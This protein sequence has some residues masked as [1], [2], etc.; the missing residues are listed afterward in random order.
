MKLGLLNTYHYDL[1]P[2]NYQESYQPMAMDFLQKYFP[3]VSIETYMVAQGELPQGPSDCDAWLITGSPMSAYDSDKWVIDLK[4][5]IVECDQEKVKM[6]GICFGHQI[7]AQALGGE[8]EKSDKGWGVGVRD[9]EVFETM[10]WM[11]PEA[12]QLSLLFS[13]Q[14]Q[15]TKLPSKAKWLAKDEFC[16]YQMYSVGNHIF[17][18]QGHPEFTPEYAKNRLDTR[19]DKVGQDKYDMAI[20]SLNTKTSAETVWKWLLGFVLCD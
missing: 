10:P 5:F 11:N 18:M 19:I 14:D 3:D 16:K 20:A 6:I 8:A 4:K 13:H 2:G 12:S 1:T 17:C 9:F 7:I 15:V